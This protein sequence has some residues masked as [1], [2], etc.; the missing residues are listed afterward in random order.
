[1]VAAASS[2]VAA[3]PHGLRREDRRGCTAWKARGAWAVIPTSRRRARGCYAAPPAQPHLAA[4]RR[5]APED[6][7]ST[8]DE[9]TDPSETLFPQAHE[10]SVDEGRKSKAE[11][12]E[13][14]R[15]KQTEAT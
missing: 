6:Y 13:E 14:A 1:M 8:L 2:S 4:R 3:L 10:P 12:A 11:R 5:A 9:V 7:G 15:R